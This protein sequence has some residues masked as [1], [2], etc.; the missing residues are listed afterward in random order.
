MMKLP[1][2]GD[3]GFTLVEI[4]IVVAIIGVLAAIGIPLYLQQLNSAHQSAA[5]ADGT[6]IN[7]QVTNLLTPYVNYGT[8]PANNTTA[9]T[10]TGTTITIT[11]TSPTLSSIANSSTPT[12]TDTVKLSTGTTLTTSGISG[13]QYCFTLTN[14]GQKAIFTDQGYNASAATCNANGSVS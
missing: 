9:I 8:A 1:Q 10:I 6:Q 7:E 12:L 4:L 13:T 3:H 5:V 2:K 14:G 11:L